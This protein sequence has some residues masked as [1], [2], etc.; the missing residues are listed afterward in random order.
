MIKNQKKK[1]APLIAKRKEPMMKKGDFYAKILKVNTYNRSYVGN[2]IAELPNSALLLLWAGMTIFFAVVYWIIGFLSPEHAPTIAHTTPT[3]E[4]FLDSLYFSIVTATSVG[5]GDIVPLG[6]SK[7]LVSIQAIT[8]LSTFAILVTKLVSQKQEHLTENLYRF[9]NEGSAHMILDEL[10]LVRQDI[11]TLLTYLTHSQ[12]LLDSQWHNF[13]IA[14]ARTQVAF[15]DIPKLY[16]AKEIVTI[17]ERRENLLLEGTERTLVRIGQFLHAIHLNTIVLPAPIA[18]EIHVLLM[19][20]H[21]LIAEWKE[22][23]RRKQEPFLRDI[24][25]AIQRIK[26]SM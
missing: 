24:T 9:T 13:A 8:S 16:S 26:E 15:Q 2:A 5:F 20:G 23:V 19:Q 10:H 4:Q 12:I 22:L 3:I 25:Q 14:V 7:I 21:T 17:S 6:F 18:K 1:R 11:D